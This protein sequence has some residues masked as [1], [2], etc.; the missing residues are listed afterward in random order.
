M[1]RLKLL[2]SVLLLSVATLTAQD[3]EYRVLAT[4]KTSTMEKELNEAAASGYRFQNAIGG[5]SAFGGKEVVA[6]MSRITGEGDERFRYR[7]LAT[8][9]TSTMQQELQS[10]A[11]EGYVYRAQT[12]FETTFGGKEVVAIL[13]RDLE[14]PNRRA[15]YRLLATSR[16]ATMDKELAQAGKLGFE[17]LGLTVAETAFGGKELVAILSRDT[18]PD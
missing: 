11:R 9:K 3:Y 12:V 8:S 17:L 16:T 6:V 18:D 2:I 10:A 7:L 5:E 15:E 13:E 4:N 14:A 1:K